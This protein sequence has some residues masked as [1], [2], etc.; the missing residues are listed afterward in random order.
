MKQAIVAEL[1]SLRIAAEVGDV[2]HPGLVAAQAVA[3][4][5]LEQGG[6]PEGRQPAL[7]AAVSRLGHLLVGIVEEALQLIDGEG[8]LLRSG[9]DLLNVGCGVALVDDLDRVCAEA[10]LADRHPVVGGVDHVLAERAQCILVGPQCRVLAAVDRP[11]VTEPFIGVLGRPDTRRMHR[12]RHV[13]RPAH[14]R[15]RR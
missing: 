15:R 6:V 14:H 7:A 3:V 13:Q 5:D 1:G 10:F 12:R 8:P 2:Q 9:L 11:Q 4:G